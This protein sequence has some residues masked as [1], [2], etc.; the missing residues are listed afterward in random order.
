MRSFVTPRDE[1]KG[2]EFTLSHLCTP[3]LAAAT[4]VLM[5]LMS[6]NFHTC[7]VILILSTRTTPAPVG[8]RR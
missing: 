1:M 7:D 5:S 2:R 4:D 6:F 8:R 3:V